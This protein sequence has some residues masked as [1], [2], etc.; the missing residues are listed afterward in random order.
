MSQLRDRT[1]VI[2]GGTSGMGLETARLVL[3]EG[4]RAVITG[5]NPAK[6]EQAVADLTSSAGPMG[7]A[8]P[9][10]RLLALQSDTS[11]LGEIE[12]AVDR[13]RGHFGGV[14]GLFANAGIGIFKPISELTEQDCDQLVDVN[15]KGLFFTVQ[16]FLPLMQDGPAERDRSILLNASWTAHRGLLGAH[17]YSAT[18][19]AVQSLARTMA[20]ELAE[21]GIRVN[22][23]SPGYIRTPIVEAIGMTQE[24]VDARAP[25]VPM[26]RWGKPEEIATVA[27]FLLSPLA[28]YVNG[29][30]ILVDGGLVGA[31]RSPAGE[32]V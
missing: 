21:H 19:A 3:A 15:L 8:G 18:K 23:I 4:G 31:H 9:A 32:V 13:V 28:S 22:S 12:R 29:Q 5:R 16:K 11:D 26:E 2:T 27:A 10:E 25:E 20:H 1:V 24:Q 7:P 14:H 6:L 30:D 17:L